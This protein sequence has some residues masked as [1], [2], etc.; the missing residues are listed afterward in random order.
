[1]AFG[2]A[3]TTGRANFAMQRVSRLSIPRLFI[4]DR[5]NVFKLVRAPLIR[6][7][8]SL[9]SFFFFLRRFSSSFVREALPVVCSLTK[10]DS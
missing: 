4:F 7:H 9:F 10:D 3:T 1:M 6:R 8:P 2:I 5:S